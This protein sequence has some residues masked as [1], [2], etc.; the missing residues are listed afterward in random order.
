MASGKTT[1]GRAVSRD[2]G[3][4][5]VDPDDYIVERE[6]LSISEL[7][8]RGE[9]VFRDAERRALCSLLKPGRPAALIACGGGTP[10]FGDNM[11]LMNSAGVTVLLEADH[12][13]LLNR[14]K[15]F[16]AQRPLLRDLDDEALTAFVERSMAS[17]RQHYEK[18]MARFDSSRLETE[19]EIAESSRRFIN[20]FL[21]DNPQQPLQ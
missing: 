7:F 4:D 11:E 12:E 19:A 6:G 1:L 9:A 5:F 17:R 14:L 10:C 13:T 16:R 20:T 2:A 21:T 18:A 15:L 3:I 8:A